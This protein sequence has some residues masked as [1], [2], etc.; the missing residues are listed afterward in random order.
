SCSSEGCLQM[1]FS[2]N[3]ILEQIRRLYEDR[4]TGILALTGDNGE[5]LDIFFRE[6][7]IEA[8]TSSSGTMRLGDYLVNGG[9][10]PAHGLDAVYSEAKRQKIFF[11]EAVV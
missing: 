9:H 3:S 8:A 10:I 2:G 7:M 5:R 6:G 11:G 1:M 4:Q